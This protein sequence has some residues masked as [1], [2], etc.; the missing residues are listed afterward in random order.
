MAVAGRMG[1]LAGC[2]YSWQA[3]SALASVQTRACERSLTRLHRLTAHPCPPLL[4]PSPP[5]PL[6]QGLTCDGVSARCVMQWYYLTGNSCD[7]PGT[8]AG[9]GAPQLGTCGASANYPEEVRRHGSQRTGN[10]GGAPRRAQPSAHLLPCTL[11]LGHP[12][13]HV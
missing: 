5:W 6:P 2:P 7:P 12:K 1:G 3:V 8:P 11:G 4:P 10:A 13:R 9:Y